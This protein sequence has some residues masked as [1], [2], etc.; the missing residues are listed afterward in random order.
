MGAGAVWNAALTN[1]TYRTAGY[2]CILNGVVST[3]WHQWPRF[4]VGTVVLLAAI[5]EQPDHGQAG[6]VAAI[7][8]V[9]EDAD[10]GPKPGSWWC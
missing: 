4:Q 8:T 6:V 7:T 10:H 2:C 1:R 3:T 9:P 5:P